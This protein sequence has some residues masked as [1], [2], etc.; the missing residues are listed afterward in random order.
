MPPRKPVNIKKR[1]APIQMQVNLAKKGSLAIII[2][3][4]FNRESRFIKFD[5][6]AEMLYQQTAQ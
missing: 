1:N 6:H 5:Q 3:H 4:L 2:F